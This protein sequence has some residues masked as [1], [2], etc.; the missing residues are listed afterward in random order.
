VERQQALAAAGVL[1]VALAIAALVYGLGFGPAM[2][3]LLYAIAG[4][5]GAWFFV[6]PLAEIVIGR[7]HGTAWGIAA[8]ILFGLAFGIAAATGRLPSMPPLEDGTCHDR[9]GS[10]RC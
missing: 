10:Y 9:Q 1:A 8:A 4:F 2:T 7:K 3:A 5:A 6:L